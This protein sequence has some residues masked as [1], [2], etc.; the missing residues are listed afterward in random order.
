MLGFLEECNIRSTSQE[1]AET[2]YLVNRD[3]LPKRKPLSLMS[4]S[5]SSGNIRDF[6]SS[7]ESF[8]RVCN[9]GK[10]LKGVKGKM[11][12]RVP[13]LL[14]SIAYPIENPR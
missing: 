6:N 1:A 3:F 8:V 7:A 12:S 9:N 14:L 4:R 11:S 13:E 10:L 2:R 5:R